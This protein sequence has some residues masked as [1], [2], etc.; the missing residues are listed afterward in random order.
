MS[1]LSDYHQDDDGYYHK[2][3]LV[4]FRWELD[5]PTSLNEPYSPRGENTGFGEHDDWLID[6]DGKRRQIVRFQ[7]EAGEWWERCDNENKE[8]A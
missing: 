6:L 3:G 2:A 8:E 5:P 7:N 4:F 1:I